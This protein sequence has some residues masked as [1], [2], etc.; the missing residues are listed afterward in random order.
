[1]YI[2]RVP[3]PRPHVYNLY[4]TSLFPRL[5]LCWFIESVYE[6]S[7]LGPVVIVPTHYTG[8]RS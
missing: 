5:F 8:T 2:I 6:D 1:M 3:S 7:G 4:L